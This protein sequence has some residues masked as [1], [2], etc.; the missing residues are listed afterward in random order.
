MHPAEHTLHGVK[1]FDKDI[2][3]NSLLVLP[4]Y[5]FGPVV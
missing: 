3:S 1:F 5:I 2:P 4:G